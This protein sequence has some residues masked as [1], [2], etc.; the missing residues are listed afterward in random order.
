MDSQDGNGILTR[1]DFESAEVTGTNARRHMQWT[2]VVR[3]CFDEDGGGEVTLHE[4]VS[5]L[6]EMA[7]ERPGDYTLHNSAL[8]L[9][10]LVTQLNI[11]FNGA[12]RA[13]LQELEVTLE[14]T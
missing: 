3:K 10:T 2:S 14:Q 11:G 5:K 1:D 7:M 8:P 6:S 12:F 13:L 4:M 9:E